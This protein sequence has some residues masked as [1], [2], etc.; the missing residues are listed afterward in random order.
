MINNFKQLNKFVIISALI[1]FGFVIPSYA[2]VFIPDTV[3]PVVGIAGQVVTVTFSGG[4]QLDAPAPEAAIAFSIGVPKGGGLTLASVTYNQN[5]YNLPI[6][7]VNL[8]ISGRFDYNQYTEYDYG[9]QNPA[10]QLQVGTHRI[11]ITC[12]FYET[13]SQNTY[14]EDFSSGMVFWHYGWPYYYSDPMFVPIIYRY[15]LGTNI[16]NVITA[17]SG[18]IP[19]C[20][21]NAS[22]WPS[23]DNVVVNAGTQADQVKIVVQDLNTNK[24]LYKE[25]VGGGNFD[26]IWSSSSTPPIGSFS[27]GSTVSGGTATI[28]I[29]KSSLSNN[30]HYQISSF[31]FNSAYNIIEPTPSSVKDF[32]WDSQAPNVTLTLND[33]QG[34]NV[35]MGYTN[36]FGP[37]LNIA[38]TDVNPVSCQYR[39][40]NAFGTNSIQ[41]P[42][43][44]GFWRPYDPSNPIS[45]LDYS[46][47]R[48]IMLTTGDTMKIF[49]VDAV[50]AVGN[51]NSLVWSYVT[52][53]TKSPINGTITV[54]GRAPGDGNRYI[55]NNPV[56]ITYSSADQGDPNYYSGMKDIQISEDN[57]FPSVGTTIAPYSAS[58]PTTPFTLSSTNGQKYIYARFEDNATNLSQPIQDVFAGTP[59]NLYLDTGLPQVAITT[60]SDG[61]TFNQIT[62]ITG[63]ASDPPFDI[64]GYSSGLLNN[65]AY[66]AIGR[67]RTGETSYKY[68]DFRTSG[69]TSKDFTD[70]YAIDPL[71]VG[72]PI[73]HSTQPVSGGNW[74]FDPGLLPA[75]DKWQDGDQYQIV[76]AVYD[77]AM[78]TA[79]ASIGGNIDKLC[80][81]FSNISFLVNGNPSQYARVGDTITLY[82]IAGETLQNNSPTI[83]ID[84][85]P[86]TTLSSHSGLSYTYTYI[87]PGTATEGKKI[88]SIT[89]T[90]QYGNSRTDTSAALAQ[91][92]PA[93][94][95]PYIYYD[96]TAPTGTVTIEGGATYTGSQFVHLNITGLDPNLADGSAG[97]GVGQ[98]KVWDKDDPAGE[99]SDVT[100]WKDL[101]YYD[102]VNFGLTQDTVGFTTKEVRVKFKDRSGNPSSNYASATIIL[103]SRAPDSPVIEAP[104]NGATI[105]PSFMIKGIAK[106]TVLSGSQSIKGGSGFTSNAVKIWIR[107]QNPSYPL[108]SSNPYLYWNGTTW[109]ESNT[110]QDPNLWIQADLSFQPSPDP[111]IWTKFINF[112]GASPIVSPDENITIF[113]RATDVAGNH[114]DSSAVV[115]TTGNSVTFNLAIGANWVSIPMLNTLI[116]TSLDLWN[117]IG[118]EDG[119]LIE[120][121]VSGTPYYG[122]FYA[123][124]TEP[125]SNFPVAYGGCYRVTSK[126]QH[127]NRQISGTAPQN[128]TGL[129][130]LVQGQNWIFLPITR[131]DI[132]TA[133]DLWISLGL[134]DGDSIQQ[135]IAGST[136]YTNFSKYGGTV[137][138]TNFNVSVGQCYLVTVSS[139]TFSAL[140]GG[141]AKKWP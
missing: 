35:T 60:P 7:Q 3:S 1:L 54:S 82:L 122:I 50:D 87:V 115:V 8:G 30:V 106:D 65:N 26:Y 29:P 44:A 112:G 118:L 99:P 116:D 133:N 51:T 47:N 125:W 2:Y 13:T 36:S 121:P 33:P 93:I 88:V 56:N 101:N 20:G 25:W 61:T 84:G 139:H 94:A 63:T 109:N 32:W 37:S 141:T 120:V 95:V 16:S 80:Q 52:L 110:T 105:F 12:T 40:Y 86:V 28:K 104:Q 41:G 62:A 71:N 31:G 59:L 78:N 107:R 113:V 135:P 117:K 10:G 57:T 69:P 6:A 92:N 43:P 129:F 97:S 103:D 132:L 15:D 24:Y 81:P 66:V 128:E 48:S 131:S 77:K 130:T 53:D 98:V 91:P 74:S 17:T 34:R 136:N 58:N 39:L 100:G 124:P 123:G 83:T 108:V 19:L 11:I 137:Y 55:K 18:S 14:E 68:F 4:L 114:T 27:L 64:S 5:G 138:G 79:E 127:V 49:A 111:D 102:T 67:K 23:N 70:A 76:T 21:P 140:W 9:I 72:L 45:F 46:Y 22:Y 85:D 38:I 126:Y 73:W 134:S 42:D 119:D 89:E 90:D 75:A 96:F